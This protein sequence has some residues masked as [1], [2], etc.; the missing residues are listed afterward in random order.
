M[1]CSVINQLIRID[2]YVTL[3]YAR[4]FVCLRL[5]SKLCSFNER[6]RIA[7]KQMKRIPVFLLVLPS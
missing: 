7:Q 5:C 2:S 6:K 1:I 4:L 3:H